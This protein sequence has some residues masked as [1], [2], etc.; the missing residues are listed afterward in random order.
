MR[1]VACFC[2]SATPRRECPRA[3][4][5]TLCS[6][7]RTPSNAPSTIREPPYHR[8]HRGDLERALARVRSAG[9]T[10]EAFLALE[11]NR[12]RSLWPRPANGSASAPSTTARQEIAELVRRHPPPSP[13]PLVTTWWATSSP[14]RSS[15]P[16]RANAPACRF[17]GLLA[18]G[19]AAAAARRAPVGVT[20]HADRCRRWLR[21]PRPGR[22]L[23][24]RRGPPAR[25]APELP[26]DRPARLRPP[27][28]APSPVHQIRPPRTRSNH[29]S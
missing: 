17:L 19:P 24:R 12:R 29:R 21:G 15:L 5:L 10:L 7:P 22:A 23:P 11:P 1:S 14:D 16:V 3:R 13:R 25:V 6:N 27:R 8:A 28:S 9:R 26:A 18:R 2:A 20:T 4:G